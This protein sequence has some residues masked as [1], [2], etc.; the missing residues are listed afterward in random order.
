[1]TRAWTTANALITKNTSR[2][3]F[4]NPTGQKALL[5][6]RGSKIEQPQ[7]NSQS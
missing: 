7:V 5:K 2:L 3:A 6:E 1:M 4:L